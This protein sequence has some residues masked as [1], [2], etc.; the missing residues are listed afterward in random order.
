MRNS[1]EPLTSPTAS[2]I[3]ADDLA[4]FFDVSAPWLTRVIERKPRQILKAVDGVS[5]A[6]E[7]GTTLALVGESGCGKSVT[8]LSIMRLISKP[9]RISGGPFGAIPTR[10]PGVQFGELM[11]KCAGI[12]DQLAIIRSMKTKQSEHLQGKQHHEGDAEPAQQPHA[13]AEHLPRNSGV[14]FENTENL[15]IYFVY[16]SGFRSHTVILRHF[17][18]LFAGQHPSGWVDEL[19][20]PYH[21]NATCRDEAGE[22]LGRHIDLSV[23]H[24]H[25]ARNT[26]AAARR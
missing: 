13:L 5:F 24:R 9:G 8:S 6:I 11:P 26:V 25:R 14:R 2:L 15:S 23:L 20:E 16:I 19:V 22:R 7:K 10:L 1:T 4:K 18:A 17:S 12:A 3:V 21:P